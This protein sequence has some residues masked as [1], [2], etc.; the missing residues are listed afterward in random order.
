MSTARQIRANRKNASK[1]T[2]PKTG[3]GR[4]KSAGNAR[5]HGLTTS[6]AQ[7]AVGRW[8]R[9]VRDDIAAVPDPMSRDEVD[10]AALALAE[11]EAR[12]ER[13]CAVEAYNQQKMLKYIDRRGRKDIPEIANHIDD[14]PEAMELIMENHDDAFTR[15]AARS[16]LR[17]HPNRP[18]ALRAEA[19]RFA[20]YRGEAEAQ[21]RRALR[22]WIAVSTG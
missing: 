6:P 1:S 11:A 19:R 16:L 10:R 12:L 8:Y 9:I 15:G 13:V 20:R 5:G 17:T 7:E 18:P 4:A 14:D 21:R 3:Q 22:R 2:G